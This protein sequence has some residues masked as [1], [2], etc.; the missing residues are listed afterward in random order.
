MDPLYLANE[1]KFISIIEDSRAE[2][3]VEFLCKDPLGREAEIIG[4][5]QEGSGKVFLKTFFGGTKYL[6]YMAGAPLP[7]IC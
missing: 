7:R 6:N 2:E 5:V 3:F 1:G 4:E